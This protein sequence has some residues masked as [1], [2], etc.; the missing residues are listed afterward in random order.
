MNLSIYIIAGLGLFLF[1]FGTVREYHRLWLAY[2]VQSRRF[3][4]LALMLVRRSMCHKHIMV[5]N[6]TWCAGG[7]NTDAVLVRINEDIT[8][9]E[10]GYRAVQASSKTPTTSD[11]TSGIQDVIKAVIKD[12][13]KDNI[14]SVNIGTTHFINAVVSADTTKLSRVAVLRLCGPFTQEIPP[15]SDFP[16]Q[17]SSIL[18]G[19]IG[20]LKGG[21]ESKLLCSIIRSLC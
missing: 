1:T 13:S 3:T 11:I 7:T 16:T 14:L 12:V 9:Q 17:L 21:I 4:G 15:F 8:A 2:Y 6:R 10:I 20:Y 5:A 19:Y 18:N